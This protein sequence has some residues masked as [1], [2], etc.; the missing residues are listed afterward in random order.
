M[1][2]EA[3]LLPLIDRSGFIFR[4]RVGRRRSSDLRLTGAARETVPVVIEEI[5]LSTESLRGLTGKEVTLVSEE[6]AAMAEGA[7]FVFF[8]NFQVLGDH[9]LLRE[10]GRIEPSEDNPQLAQLVNGRPLQRR[11]AA[12][13]LI[14][15]G[16]VTICSQVE[17]SP[18]AKSEHDPDWW[19]ARVA[20]QS[21]IKGESAASEIEVLFANSMDIAWYKS[22]K[23]REGLSRILILRYLEASEA[24]QEVARSIYQVI[25]PLDALPVER[26]PEVQR[27]NER[28]K[29][30][31]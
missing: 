24:P 25:D 19:V 14:V 17:K 16:N 18:G 22:P 12:A 6:P 13:D 26:L 11:V 10:V 1:L 3:E 30:A 7:R 4:G 21:V 27:A 31:R 2:A 5:L 9:A 15:M 8:A 29:G 20:V 28:A 23:L